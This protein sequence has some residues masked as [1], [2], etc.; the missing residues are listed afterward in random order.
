MSRVGSMVAP[1]SIILVICL[2]FQKYWRRFYQFCV[3]DRIYG[4]SSEHYRGNMLI[5]SEILEEVLSVL[6][7]G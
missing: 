4:R 1:Q 2:L 5:I 7:H 3:M 6:C